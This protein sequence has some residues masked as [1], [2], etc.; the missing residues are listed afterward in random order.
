MFDSGWW[1]HHY[2]KNFKVDWRKIPAHCHCPWIVNTLAVQVC[3][4][5]LYVNHSQR[6]KWRLAYHSMTWNNDSH[7][8]NVQRSMISTWKLFCR[9]VFKLIFHKTPDTRFRAIISIE[10]NVGNSLKRGWNLQF[11]IRA[12]KRFWFKDKKSWSSSSPFTVDQIMHLAFFQTNLQCFRSFLQEVAIRLY[13]NGQQVWL[14][15]QW[16]P[17]SRPFFFV[18]IKR[19]YWNL[20]V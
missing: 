12:R 5:F 18:I 3:F 14:L 15:I 20:S 19:I 2:F 16:P 13:A 17:C 10:C 8:L 4:S 7:L 11:C 9:G 6:L 1:R